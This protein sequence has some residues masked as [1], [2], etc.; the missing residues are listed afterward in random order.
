MHVTLVCANANPTTARMFRKNAFARVDALDVTGYWNLERDR[1]VSVSI[2]S[3]NNTLKAKPLMVLRNDPKRMT[4]FTIKP[5]SSLTQYAELF[6][7][8]PT[9][10]TDSLL[11]RRR[12]PA[13]AWR[14]D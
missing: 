3:K 1:S 10:N 12:P 13:A 2:R 8:Y 9:I 14:T 6:N 5:V 11:I 7:R 4:H